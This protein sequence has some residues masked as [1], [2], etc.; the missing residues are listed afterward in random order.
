VVMFAAVLCAFG[1]FLILMVAEVFA[2]HKILKGEYLRKFVHITSGSFIAFWPWL[3][4]WHWLQL[5]GLAML[6]V[7][8]ANHYVSFF[9]YHGHR[10]SF[11]DIYLALAVFLSATVTSK[12][13]FFCLAILEVALADGLAALVGIKY[14]KHWR[15]KVLGHPKTV[16][17][18]MAFWIISLVI[19]G[20]GLLPA[21]QAISYHSYYLLLLIM[22]P[23]LTIAENLSISGLD[24]LIIPL[25]TIAI[26]RSFQV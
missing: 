14:G 13:I 18:S 7:T 15:Y 11:G 19:L 17:G 26:L 10:A 4:S 9:S 1:T 8:T 3:V 21:H 20:F 22:P 23:L 25:V 5:L 6:V 24:N 12:K 2:A 16:I